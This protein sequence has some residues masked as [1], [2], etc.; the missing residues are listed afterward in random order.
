M[1]VPHELQTW[2]VIIATDLR[3]AAGLMPSGRI[4]DPYT[5]VPLSG[6]NPLKERLLDHA[7]K[8]ERYADQIGH[9]SAVREPSP[10]PGPESF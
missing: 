1:T 6:P 4:C 8:A 9:L 2:L 3:I 7:R 10:V 5:G